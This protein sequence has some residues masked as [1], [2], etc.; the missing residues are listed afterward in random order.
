[1]C[2]DYGNRI[3]Y[4]AYVEAFGQLNVRVSEPGGAP[5]LEPRDDIWPTDTAPIVRSAEDGVEL[6]QLR[7]GFPPRP[8]KGTTCH[9][10]AVREPAVPARPLPGAGFAFLRVH[11]EA[12]AQSEVALHEVR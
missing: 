12:I 3:P 6:V 7:W 1:M 4:D 11:G 9:Q 2:N 5:N 8:S 10:H